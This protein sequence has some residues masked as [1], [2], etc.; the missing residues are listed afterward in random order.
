[1][2]DK[3]TNILCTLGPA[4][5]SPLVLRQMVRSGMDAVRLNTAHG[6]FEQHARLI[7]AVRRIADLPIVVDIKGP[8]VRIE[9]SQELRLEK[10][11]T[12]D[13][14]FTKKHPVY[15]TRDIYSQ[16]QAGDDLSIYDG[17][18]KTRVSDKRRGVVTLRIIEGG[19]FKGNKGVNIPGRHLDI[20]VIGERDRQALRMALHEK[21]DFIALSF[22]RD[23]SDLQEL[24]RH[25]A[26]RKVGLIAKIENAE[27]VRK[28]NEIIL[29]AD[30]IMVA[31]GDLG[32]EVPAEKLPLIQKDIILKSNIQGKFSIVATEM[33]KSMVESSRPT[34]AETS[35]VANAVL[36][37]ADTVML[38]EETSIGKHPVE[39]VWTM[40]KILKE[41]EPYVQNRM[42]QVRSESIHASIA[43]AV[44]DICQHLP[45]DKIVTLTRS[46]HTARLISRFRLHKDIIAITND[47]SVKRRLG[48]SYGVT[49]LV[50]DDMPAREKIR[51]SALFLHK[52]GLIKPDETVLFTAGIYTDREHATNIIQ[53]HRIR[54]FMAYCRRHG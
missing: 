42:P 44:Y 50:Y 35:D 33:L 52:K 12:L 5:E 3:K 17:L 46:G 43:K 39:S 25:L 27:G 38:S 2:L 4:C 18:I 40:A 28:I 11:D 45:V 29:A 9:S 15:F 7:R 1:M 53:I 49:A 24:R 19:C 14:G 13:V 47:H 51:N 37:G 48:L 22:V 41:A 31:R 36:D 20:P 32:V 34:R 23:A 30:G 16:I 10:G 8:E 54:E 26:G 21:A 6:S